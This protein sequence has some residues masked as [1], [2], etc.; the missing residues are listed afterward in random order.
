MSAEGAV[1]ARAVP[2]PRVGGAGAAPL[3][4]PPL[5][6]SRRCG[7][8]PHA[9]SSPRLSTATQPCVLTP[10]PFC[11]HLVTIASAFLLPA[12]AEQPRPAP[13][14]EIELS[15]AADKVA[16]MARI[17]VIGAGLGAMAA[18]ARLAVA[19]H[20]VVVHERTATYGGAV[21]RFERDG[22]AL[23]H[24]PGA[25]AAAR[26]LPR[27]VPQDRQGAAGEVRR[28]GPGRPGG[29]ARLR[30]RHGRPAAQRLTRGRGRRPG[31][32]ARLG[33]GR[34]LGRLPGARPRGLGPYPAARS[35]RS[36][37]GPTGRCSP[38][39]NPTPRCPT[40]GFCAPAAPAPSP[41]SPRGSCATPG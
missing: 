6:R 26:R 22:F 23:R 33:R 18:A 32:G 3:P 29:P 5:S 20:G 16:A 40:D 38:S 9:Y 27:S 7:A 24:G 25:A 34:P 13:S 11:C 37:C 35:W 19:G 31:H 8:H 4:V 14:R 1:R 10:R 12:V 15:V 28:A 2:P 17:A 39:A 36:R 30:G 21:G 41:R